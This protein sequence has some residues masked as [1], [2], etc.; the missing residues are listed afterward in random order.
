MLLHRALGSSYPI[1]SADD[2]SLRPK[3]TNPGMPLPCG[4]ILK[5]MCLSERMTRACVLTLP[6]S[7]MNHH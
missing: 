3:T 1:T 5:T 4:I 2:P 6:I 7:L